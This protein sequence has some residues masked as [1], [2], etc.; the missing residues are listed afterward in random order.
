M[1]SDTILTDDAGVRYSYDNL[2]TQ[3][4]LDGH[5]CGLEAAVKFVHEHAVTLFRAGKDDEAARA[6]R[7]AEDMLKE[8]HPQMV[9]R[10]K[11]H[12]KNHPIILEAE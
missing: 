1:S 10:A 12:A 4:W 2:K 5:A 6:R 8:L 11:D 3:G 9:R 7:L